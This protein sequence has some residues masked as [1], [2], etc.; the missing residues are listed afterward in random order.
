[1]TGDAARAAWL[2]VGSCIGAAIVYLVDAF[3]LNQGALAVV[4]ALCF[5]VV[6]VFVLVYA[7]IKRDLGRAL[8]WVVRAG[9]FTLT[10]AAVLGTN[11]LQNV[12]ARHRAE[13]VIAACDRY[14]ALHGEYPEQLSDLVPAL[15]AIVPRAKYVVGF[16]RFDYHAAVGRHTLGYTALPPFG[17]PFYV[18]EEHRW[19]YLD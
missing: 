19:G 7:A 12:L 13:E 17:R 11:H 18:L 15:L 10:A 2:P 16:G 9:M 3:V 4:A 6:F 1:V 5:I 14:R 8:S